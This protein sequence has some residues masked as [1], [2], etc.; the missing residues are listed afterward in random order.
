VISSQ[1]S[2]SAG[3]FTTATVDDRII[4]VMRFILALSALLITIVDPSEPDRLVAITY[5]ALTLYTIYS[6][7]LYVTVQRFQAFQARIRKW[8]HWAD[9]GWYLVLIGLSSGTSSVFFFFFFFAIL[10]A[11]FRWGF[12]SGLSVT[13]ISAVLFTT[14]GFV[15]APKGLD[16][17]LNRFL[18]RPIYLFV[19][20]YMMAYWGGYEITLKRR[21][22]LLKEVNTLANPR[23]GVDRTTGWLV[24][25]LRGFYDADVC[26][27]VTVDATSGEHFI[28]RVGRENPGQVVRN[29]PFPE[30]LAQRLLAL[31]PSHA[32]V[33]SSKPHVWWSIHARVRAYEVATRARTAESPEVSKA[34]AAMLDAGSF[35]AV[36]LRHQHSVTG[37]IYLTATRRDAFDDSDVDF[38][39]QVINHF[40]P[41]I[42][43]IRL[44]DRLASDAAEVERQRIAHDIHDSVIQPYIGLQIGLTAIIQKLEAGDTNAIGDIKRLNEQIAGVVGNLRSYMHGLANSGEHEN[45]LVPS[46]RR[47]AATFAETTGIG[48]QIEAVGDMRLNDRLSAQVFQMVTEGL[49]NIRR[50]TQAMQARIVLAHRDNCVILRIED[51]SINAPAPVPFIPRSITERATTLGGQARVDQHEY[52][53][54]VI[55]E[56]PL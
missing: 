39:L 50:H 11:S 33:Y 43:N 25:R 49:S 2:T 41:V 13:V 51:Q 14:V 28:R 6:A 8:T 20:G 26:L 23:F 35:V 17:E 30:K 37:R 55:V 9:V 21:L 4:A 24:E 18:L 54:A 31:P 34:V 53:S 16:F 40:T 48:V 15:T 47:F 29:E 7:T 38:L 42:E 52:G 3:T 19:L 27:L 45:I 56:I 44:V 5:A 46:V 12:R 10:V 32:V 22:A 1:P 36:P